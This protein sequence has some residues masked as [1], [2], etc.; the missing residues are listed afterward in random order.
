MRA[1]HEEEKK[2]WRRFFFLIMISIFGERIFCCF[3]GNQYCEQVG[4]GSCGWCGATF[5][6]F[7]TSRRTEVWELVCIWQSTCQRR[8]MLSIFNDLWILMKENL[9]YLLDL[10]NLANWN[11]P[12]YVRWR[13][14]L[15]LA[16]LLWFIFD[17]TMLLHFNPFSFSRASHS[18]CTDSDLTFSPPR[19]PSSRS[20]SCHDCKAL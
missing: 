20:F 13:Y 6:T 7:T 17:L 3:Q 19:P 9:V 11:V 15:W 5:I 10:V 1:R 16:F 12:S 18:P 8:V 4:I 2:W 14:E